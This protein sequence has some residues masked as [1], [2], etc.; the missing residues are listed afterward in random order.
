M[1]FKTFR[2]IIVGLGVVLGLGTCV[3]VKWCADARE[4]NEA[5]LREENDRRWRE[6]VAAEGERVARQA[7]SDS[8]GASAAPSGGPSLRPVDTDILELLKR[9]AQEKIKDGAR[10]K[11]WKV[12]VYSDDR[13]RFNRVKVDLDRDEKWDE[14]WTVKPDGAIERKVAPA[15]DERYTQTL[16]LDRAAG[17][18]DLAG[19]PPAPVD[20][21]AAPIPPPAGANAVGPRPVDKDMAALLKQ[22]AQVKVKD[23]TKGKPYKINLYSDDRQR[24]NRAKVDL[25]RDNQWDESWTFK[26]DGAT[27]RKVAPADDENYTEVWVLTGSDWKR[28]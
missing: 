6:R 15:D 24:F 23:A 8:Q 20:A 19:P 9:P 25:D 18:V 3:G 22:P 5:R 14:S 16:R 7:A 21:P 12:N 11:P 17:W 4:V 26:A 2:N 13:R 1:R 10:G 27:E 28:K